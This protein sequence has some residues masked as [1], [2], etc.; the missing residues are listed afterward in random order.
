M[1]F[2]SQNFVFFLIVLIFLYYGPC[3]K[4]QWQLILLASYIFYYFSG[5]TNLFY[6][7]FTTVTTY[8]LTRA[9]QKVSDE[10]S[11]F[12]KSHKEDMSREERKAYK[13][14]RKK[15]LGRLLFLDILCNI[16]L[17]AVVKYTNFTI[18]NINAVMSAF[19]SKNVLG[20]WDIALPMGISFYVF[21][22]VGYAIDVYRGKVRAERNFFKLACFISF[23]PQL[24]Q[25][26]IS[27]FDDL[28]ETLFARHEY[29]FD[30]VKSGALRVLWGFFKKLVIA[31]RLLVA[32][33]TIIHDPENYYGAF[34][35][36]GMV[37]YGIEL[38]ADFTGGID[39]TIGVAEILGIRVKENFKRPYFSKS[40]KEFWNRWHITMG[41]WFTDYIF[42]PL[43]VSK[44]ML[45]LSHNSRE[46]LGD[47]FG[48]RVPV[49][50][51]SLIVWFATG[52]W[53]GAS[54]NFIVWGIGNFVIIMISQELTPFY[55][56][57]HSKCNVEGKKSWSAFQIIRTIFIMSS[58]RTFDCYRD[59]PLTFRMY[60][61]MFTHAN[62][63]NVI[64]SWNTLGLEASDYVVVML[65]VILMFA[66]S[67]ISRGVGMG[68]YTELVSGDIRPAEASARGKLFAKGYW[69]Q[70]A[71][72]F[73]L[74]LVVLI[75]GNYGIGFDS[76]QFIY[77]QF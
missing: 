64:A 41:T 60:G 16:G 58:L 62:F 61:S 40:I 18:S 55:R 57:F 48:K 3:R 70:F 37:F 59:V 76:S 42:Y 47:K 34:V 31:D 35:F 26:P 1:L 54:W 73:L 27:R 63:G 53:H 8:L 2:A 67:M 15:I 25:G 13:A 20:F 72:I 9:M 56:W 66:V 5:V 33:N 21:Q 11:A 19:G 28:K 75:L 30:R 39:I 6:I 68:E 77:N 17:L 46:K 7:A 22:S 32:V 10:T 23:F 45:K 52:L 44:W 12:V 14:S 50:L 65:G 29:D 43:S 51:S 49:Y 4:F 36:V 38:Y 74:F 71:V 69:T 24:V